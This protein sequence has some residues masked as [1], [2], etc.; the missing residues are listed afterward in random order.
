MKRE[1]AVWRPLDH[2]NVTQFLGIVHLGERMPPC[3][4]SPYLRRNDLL[5]YIERYPELKLA[6]VSQKLHIRPRL[7]PIPFR[8]PGTGGCRRIEVLALQDDSAR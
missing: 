6:K 1:I 5:A 3:M 2:P 8:Y 7:L 4:V